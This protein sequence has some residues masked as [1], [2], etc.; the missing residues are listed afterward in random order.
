MPGVQRQEDGRNASGKGTGNGAHIRTGREK[1]SAA[2]WPYSAELQLL[3]IVGCF[4]ELWLCLCCIV[5]NTVKYVAALYHPSC[6]SRPPAFSSVEWPY[7]TLN[8]IL[9]HQEKGS[10]CWGTLFCMLTCKMSVLHVN[11]VASTPPWCKTACCDFM[12]VD[13]HSWRYACQHALL[14]MST[15]IMFACWHANVCMKTCCL[16][17]VDMQYRGRQYLKHACWT[18]QTFGLLWGISML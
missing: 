14:C 8:L 16:S 11:V 4:W 9:N 17:N 12:H 13:M 18:A 1:L 7:S 6:I 5:P 2:M 10:A 15:C 3:H